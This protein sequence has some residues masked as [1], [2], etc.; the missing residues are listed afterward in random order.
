MVAADDRLH[1]IWRVALATGLRSGELLGLTWDDA[2]E[3]SVHVRRQVLLRPR[4]VQGV[5]RLF[6]RS[7]LKNRRARR[8]RLD[9]QTATELRRWK[10]TQ[11]AERLAFGPAWKEDGGLG[12]QADWIVTE[13]DGTVVH[14]DTLLGRWKRLVKVAG[15]PAIPLHGAALL[16]GARAL[17]RRST[18]RRESDA[19]PQQQRVHRGPVQPR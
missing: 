12:V 14:P 15:V 4:A 1:A 7:T 2:D 8:V 17:E 11:S 9:E 13:A 18:G 3:G 10:A 16:R 5:R 6:V 19:R